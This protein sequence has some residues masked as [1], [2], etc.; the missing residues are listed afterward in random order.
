[1]SDYRPPQRGG[2]SVF[3]GILLGA[4]LAVAGLGIAAWLYT[5]SRLMDFLRSPLAAMRTRIDVSQ[6]TVVQQIQRL[7]RLETVRFNMEKIVSGER[8]LEYLPKWLI[9][10]RL[11]LVVEGEAVAGVDLGKLRPEDVT[12]TGRSVSVTLPR[13]EL[14]SIRIDNE[15]TRVYSRET[16]LF[17][18]LD[19]QL[20]T[21]V[22]REAERQLRES[23]MQAKILD[24]ANEN[25]RATL[26]SFLRG[27]GFEQVEVR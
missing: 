17:S 26:T 25:A 27:L 18:A 4:F 9:G 15:R 16:G 20:E 6:P 24:H 22:R 3:A 12:V 13:A 1:M 8:E 14:F 19:P 10:D 23:A 11:L 21:D 5:G 7:Q 2:G